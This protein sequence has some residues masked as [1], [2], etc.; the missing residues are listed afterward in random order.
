[1]SGQRIYDKRHYCYYCGNGF[2]RVSCHLEQSHKD[3]EE[4]KLFKT[5]KGKGKHEKF[6]ELRGLR[7]FHHNTK[8][9]C[10]GGVLV[11]WRRPTIDMVV[12]YRNYLRCEHCL[13]FMSKGKLWRH[14][15][16]CFLRKDVSSRL[17]IVKR[18][19][20]LLYPNQHHQAVSEELKALVMVNMLKDDIIK[21]VSQDE[22]IL[23][24]RSFMLTSYGI[25]KANSISQRM[26]I[27]ARLL[28]LLRSKENTNSITLID[29]LIPEYFDM[30][31]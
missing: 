31:V 7:D 12:D 16:K 18:A 28:I 20:I 6:H 4:V 19:K 10:N 15:K 26:R 13:V 29:V 17:S 2:Q 24:Y 9:L 5:L 25:R 27:L 8:V 3:R 1:M 14:E 11:V 30:I 23:T 21:V 22:V